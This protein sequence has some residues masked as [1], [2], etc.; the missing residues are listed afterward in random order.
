[1]EALWAER[2]RPYQFGMADGAPFAFAGFWERWLAPDKQTLE[3]CTILTT[4]PN[5]LVSDVHD[6][7]PAILTPENYDRWLD[8]GIR[9]PKRV[10]DCLRPFDPKLMKK[11]AVSSRVNRPENDDEECAREIQIEQTALLF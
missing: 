1:M 10:L 11:H 4:T 7:M 9:D 5:S 2:K 8:P 6:R 3:S